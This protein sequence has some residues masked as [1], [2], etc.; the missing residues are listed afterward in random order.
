MGRLVSLVV[1][2]HSGRLAAGVAELAAQ[3]APAVTI[4]AAGGLEDGG[5]GTSFDTVQAALE[6]ATADGGQAVVLTD[7]GSAVLT[8]E[9]VLEFLEPEQ[10]ERITLADAPLV[11]GA[12][13]AAVEAENGAD[14]PAVAAAAEAAGALYARAGAPAPTGAGAATEA[15]QPTTAAASPGATAGPTDDGV[16]T[17]ED[18]ATSDTVVRTVVLRN[19]M[20]LHARPAAVLARAMA[21]FDAQ[22]EIGGADGSSV[23][24]L[25]A[26]GATQ[27]RELQVRATGRPAR[28][29]VETVA[30]MVDDGFGEL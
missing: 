17:T 9:S 11:E 18:G 2:S 21:G 19:A 6:Q 4:L 13:A 15:P 7:L 20:G 14:G 27:G 8:T 1:V 25:M 28:E 24:A 23:L 22:V 10:A 29:A 3:M 30:S 26:L 12:V 16:A 5:I